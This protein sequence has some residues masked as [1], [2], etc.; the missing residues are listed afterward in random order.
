MGIGN[1]STSKESD[2]HV[3][4]EGID[5]CK[6][7]IRDASGRVTVM[8]HLPHIISTSTHDAKPMLSDF[9][10]FAGMLFH[11]EIDGWVSHN[12]TGESEELTHRVL[13]FGYTSKSSGA[14]RAMRKQT[15]GAFPASVPDRW[16][17]VG[18]C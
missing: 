11:P 15:R 18:I 7:R 12:R 2:I 1:L 8:Q 13:D 4:F 9:A 3:L 6:C 5:V 14:G 17:V 16:F 10:Q